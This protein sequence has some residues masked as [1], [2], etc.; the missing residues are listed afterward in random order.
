MPEGKGEFFEVRVAAVADPTPPVL[1]GEVDAE[2]LRSQYAEIVEQLKNMST[3]D[4]NNQVI[5]QR[6]WT[7]CNACL[8][9]WLEDPFANS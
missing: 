2:E 5:R 6:I 1:D 4:A 7:L 8:E 9:A 3:L